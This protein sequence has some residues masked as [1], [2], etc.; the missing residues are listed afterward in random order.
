ML[1]LEN[2]KQKNV[3]S[4]LCLELEQRGEGMWRGKGLTCRLACTFYQMFKRLSR[5]LV[6]KKTKI[7]VKFLI[8]TA[9]LSYLRH[10][11]YYVARIGKMFF[12]YDSL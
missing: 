3:D 1:A 2:H 12:E 4:R 9:I 11:P 6:L 5:I 8:I 7:A 10:I